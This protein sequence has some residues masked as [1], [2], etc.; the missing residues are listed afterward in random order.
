MLIA[1]KCRTYKLFDECRCNL[2]IRVCLFLQMRFN[3]LLMSQG[4][5]LCKQGRYKIFRKCMSS[6]IRECFFDVIFYLVL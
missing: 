4:L 2:I 1:D 3:P 5:A 6:I